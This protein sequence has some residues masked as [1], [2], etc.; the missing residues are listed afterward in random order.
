MGSPWTLAEQISK[1]N[2]GVLCGLPVVF[3]GN[4]CCASRR[5]FLGEHNGSRS[6]ED[7]EELHVGK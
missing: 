5:R 6:D 2:A 1:A 3:M 4:A 7:G